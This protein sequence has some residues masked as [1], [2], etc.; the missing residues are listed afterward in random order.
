VPSRAM[1]STL[2]RR[3]GAEGP[4]DAAD[5]SDGKAGGGR[6]RVP[7]TSATT[8]GSGKTFKRA[9]FVLLLARLAS[10]ALNLVHDCDETYNFWEPLHYL[11]HGHG[12]QTWEHAPRFGLRS[13]AYLGAHAL[14]AKPAAWF[15]RNAVAADAAHETLAAVSRVARV[16]PFYAVRLFLAVASALADAFLASSVAETHPLAGSVTLASLVWSAGCFVSSTSF[17]PS[18]FAGVCV[19]CALAHVL[20]QQHRAACACCVAAVVWGWPFAGVAAIPA[21]LDCLSRRGFYQT[22]A[23]I[24]KPLVMTV[25]VSIA[26]DTYFYG[27]WTCSV[28]NL[29]RYNVFPTEKG[30]GANLYGVEPATFYLKN[31]AL[32]FAHGLV[33][34]LCA[35]PL[36]LIAGSKR[37]GRVDGSRETHLLLMTTH[38]PFLCSLLLFSALEHKEERFMYV[39]YSSLCA[40]SGAAVGAFFDVCVAKSARSRVAAKRAGRK[41]PGGLVLLA[42]TGA[43]AA[44]LLTAAMGASRVAALL[45][46]YGAPARAYA[47]GLPV[48]SIDFPGSNDASFPGTESSRRSRDVENVQNVCVGDEWHR[49]PS[50]FFLPSH[51]YRLKFLDAS[52]DG[53]LPVPFEAERGGTSFG[54]IFLNDENRGEREQ[55]VADAAREC[56]YVVEY[57]APDEDEPEKKA[58]AFGAVASRP[59]LGKNSDGRLSVTDAKTIAESE[60]EDASFE[61]GVDEL[62]P[63]RLRSERETSVSWRILWEAPFLDAARSPA[64]SRAF[65]VPGWSS[66]RNVYGT[67]R[68]YGKESSL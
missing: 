56:D 13:Y 48:R 58:N 33:L 3:R 24:V 68:V 46:G 28:W 14:I 43:G 11:T 6:V 38:A 35:V 60:K 47:L 31:L 18:A 62:D 50:S 40:G 45:I 34:A 32:N 27:A 36:G 51:S 15:V 5:D 42:A 21:G 54:S 12:M 67:Y 2:R 17:L 63:P 23:F 44:C 7:T 30:G 49:F 22:A 37:Y 39:A 4:N 65:F 66:K 20:K 57:V 19:T 16:A 10:A 25:T 53:A 64:L 55:R 59:Y 61:E 1:A 52:F 9:F 29:L 41:P 26:V 8:R